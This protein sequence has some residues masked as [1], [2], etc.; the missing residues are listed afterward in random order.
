MVKLYGFGTL[1]PNLASILGYLCSLRR[2]DHSLLELMPVSYYQCSET[3]QVFG[4][5]QHPTSIP[6]A[7]RFPGIYPLIANNQKCNQF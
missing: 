1:N 4:G 2:F 5:N 6:P 3:R 7:F